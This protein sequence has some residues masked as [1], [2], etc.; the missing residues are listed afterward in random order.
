MEFFGTDIYMPVD[1][2]TFEVTIETPRHPTAFEWVAARIVSDFGSSAQFA[3]ASVGDVFRT[4]LGGEGA[5]AFL[6]TALDELFSSTVH[7]LETDERDVDPL[8]LPISRIRV[9]DEGRR[10][11]ETGLLPSEPNSERREVTYDPISRK[12]LTG[13][14]RGAEDP[15][16]GKTVD[17]GETAAQPP[18]DLVRTDAER[19]LKEGCRV[20]RVVPTGLPHRSWRRQRVFF[21]L[22]N[23]KV[24]LSAE[25]GGLAPETVAYLTALSPKRAKE[26]FFD[27]VFD[28]G[29]EF[30]QH[31]S[32]LPADVTRVLT[33]SAAEGVSPRSSTVVMKG[34]GAALSGCIASVLE[35]VPGE[36][37]EL[38]GETGGLLRLTVPEAN[39]PIPEGGIC[40]RETMRVPCRIRCFYEGLPLEL[41]VVYERRVDDETKRKLMDGLLQAVSSL[42]MA[43]GGKLAFLLADN[44]EKRRQAVAQLMAATSGEERVSALNALLTDVHVRNGYM[45]F[46]AVVDGV[47][48]MPGLAGFKD[49]EEAEALMKALPLSPD[50]IRWAKGHLARY[51]K[52]QAAVGETPEN[53]FVWVESSSKGRPN[54]GNRMKKHGKRNR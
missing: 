31:V 52:G 39:Y 33:P 24:K 15:E 3:A 21:A 54:R 5:E 9:T 36:K 17:L 48:G 38:T 11:L 35:V 20:G 50:E 28:R 19:G 45:D 44:H 32:E 47:F 51:Q 16:P 4:A 29:E 7:V 22:E 12:I 26:L 30:P 34:K 43:S 23:G 37:F 46:H 53:E 8:M 18:V 41:P 14:F 6:V 2:H 42:P 1:R 25:C 27:A 10:L 40:D 49:V 13:K